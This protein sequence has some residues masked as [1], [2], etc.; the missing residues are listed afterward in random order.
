M[1]ATGDG[2][3][4][5]DPFDLPEWLGVQDVSWTAVSSLGGALVRGVLHAADG[6]GLDC[7][8]L[9]GDLAYPQPVLTERWRT[10]AHAAWWRGEALLLR[11]DGRLTVVLPGSEVTAAP[12]L[13][14]V[15]RLAKAVGASADRFTVVLRL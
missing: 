2:D 10:A 4:P 3:E 14:A 13:D 5:V 1:A 9:A 7:D 15:G 6:A 11:H 8:L 12:A